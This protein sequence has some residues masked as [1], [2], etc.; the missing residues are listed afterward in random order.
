VP[1]CT[2]RSVCTW[3]LSDGC[4]RRI[5][6]IVAGWLPG[7]GRFCLSSSHLR[8][9]QT[10]LCTLAAAQFAAHFCQGV[11]LAIVGIRGATRPQAHHVSP[12]VY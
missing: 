6:A 4:K 11:W 12:Q 5:D 9:W 8:S 2:C 10:F 7:T 3:R 1:Y